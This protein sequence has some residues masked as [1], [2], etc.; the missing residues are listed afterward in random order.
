MS[1]QS[2][3][4]TTTTTIT[5]K[6][7]TRAGRSSRRRKRKARSIL[8]AAALLLST[9]AASSTVTTSV[10]T[11]RGTTLQGVYIRRR[12]EIRRRRNNL[13]EKESNR[14]QLTTD[15]DDDDRR[16]ESL[17]PQDERQLLSQLGF[18]P[19]NA[20]GVAAR[21]SSEFIRNNHEGSGGDSSP[22]PP[23]VLKL[24]PMAIRDLY[25]GGKTDGRKFKGRRRGRTRT[26]ADADATVD[27]VAKSSR[28]ERGGLVDA[29]T[30]RGIPPSKPP[31]IVEPFPTLYWLT[32]PR[33][34]CY[35]SRLELSQMHNVARMERRLRSSTYYLDQMARAHLS[36]GKQRWELLTPVDREEVLRRGWGNAL[37]CGRGVAGIRPKVVR[38]SRREGEEHD[39]GEIVWD[40]VKCLHAHAAHFLAQLQ[41]WREESLVQRNG[42]C[43]FDDRPED[44][45]LST[46]IRECDRDDL[47]L[48]GKWTMEAVLDLLSTS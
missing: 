1:N 36:Y 2:P 40:G 16:E 30:T 24:Y 19:G 17:D 25:R 23:S 41:E 42:R 8:D 32:C 38:S 33:L 12:D 43:I 26:D 45:L 14:E 37:D 44:E 5:T 31:Q 29:A 28:R 7:P 4:P 9:D 34:R 11:D 22:P 21:L 46:L 15:D 3:P 13:I 6:R 18:I 47:N 27:D 48:V 35:V 39:V 10:P 20:V